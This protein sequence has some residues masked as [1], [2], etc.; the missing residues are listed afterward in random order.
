MPLRTPPLS[1]DSKCATRQCEGMFPIT[2]SLWSLPIPKLLQVGGNDAIKFFAI[3]C[4]LPKDRGQTLHLFFEMLVLIFG[5]RSA[6]VAGRREDATAGDDFVRCR[7]LAEALHVLV[8]ACRF[9]AA[10]SVIRATQ[11]T[12]FCL[13]KLAMSAVHQ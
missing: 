1:T 11:S 12:D 8:L 2:G 4:L 13:G 10:P 7:P 9:F 3:C 5:F 6:C